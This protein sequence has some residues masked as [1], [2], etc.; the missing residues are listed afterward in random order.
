MCNGVRSRP[1]EA[2]KGEENRHDE[3]AAPHSTEMVEA[4][5]L[6]DNF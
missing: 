2:G 5:C 3:A 4:I 1:P 6:S